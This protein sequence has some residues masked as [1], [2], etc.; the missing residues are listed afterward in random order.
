[1]GRVQKFISTRL[2]NVKEIKIAAK[3]NMNLLFMSKENSDEEKIARDVWQNLDKIVIFG[4]CNIMK[5]LMEIREKHVSPESS[6]RRYERLPSLDNPCKLKEYFGPLKSSIIQLE[7]PPLLRKVKKF[8]EEITLEPLQNFQE[9]KSRKSSESFVQ[10][11]DG[12][13]ERCTNLG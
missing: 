8:P 7:S 10:A 9:L 3:V 4:L 2:C 12:Q 13:F 11:N 6:W 1:M 5:L